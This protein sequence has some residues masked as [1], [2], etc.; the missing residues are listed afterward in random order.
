MSIGATQ[1]W[2]DI[3][4]EPCR[5]VSWWMEG[6][7]PEPDVLA[8]RVMADCIAGKVTAIEAREKLDAIFAPT[9]ALPVFQDAAAMTKNTVS[10]PDDVIEGI[11]HRGGKIVF[12]GASKSFK[13]WLMIDLAVT[14]ATGSKW[15]GKF[16]TKKGAVLYVNFELPEPY[17][18]WRIKTLCEK[19]S[20]WFDPGM[21]TVLNLRGHVTDWPIMRRQIPADKFALIILD[22]AYK[23]LLGKDENRTSDI[24]E[25]FETFDVLAART[26]ASIATD[27]HYSKGNQAAKEDIDRT[28]GSGVFARDPDSLINLTRHE[29]ENS[30]TVS[31]TLRNHPQQKSFVVSWEFPVFIPDDAADPGKLRQPG[32]PCEHTAT[33][34]RALI[35]EPMTATAIVRL[36]FEELQIS[37]RR[38]FELL[39]ECKRYK[40]LRQLEKGGIYE[41]V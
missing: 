4:P 12:G 27:H 24:G 36:A 7:T 5:Q 17:F 38:T 11:V 9:R 29:K 10:L 3:P 31:M 22:P 18:W 19:T 40:W 25:L 34:L 8:K 16:P 28:S 35:D 15:L 20:T 37:R 32:R 14:V 30:F 13:T 41:P 1:G 39:K 6:A 21:L 26:G 23:L 2:K 33:E